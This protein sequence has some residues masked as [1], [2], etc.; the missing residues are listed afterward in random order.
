MSSPTTSTPTGVSTPSAPPHFTS[1]MLNVL[2]HLT[3]SELFMR[4][5]YGR[6]R[7][8]S[9][10]SCFYAWLGEVRAGSSCPAVEATLGAPDRRP[11]RRAAGARG[12]F[13]LL[14]PRTRLSQSFHLQTEGGALLSAVT[15]SAPR[16]PAAVASPDPGSI[17]PPGGPRL[18]PSVPFLLCDLDPLQES[19]WHVF[20]P[21]GKQNSERPH[22]PPIVRLLHVPRVPLRSGLAPGTRPRLL[23]SRSLPCCQSQVFSARGFQGASRCP[24]SLPAT[25]RVPPSVH[26]RG[27]RSPSDSVLHPFLCRNPLRDDLNTIQ[28]ATPSPIH[29]FKPNPLRGKFQPLSRGTRVGRRE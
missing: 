7:G 15:L 29:I 14:P 6:E 19:P 12:F 16:T 2:C 4:H 23:L 1:L 3:P 18:L 22:S 8:D 13:L 25:T 21:R 9:L 26:D 24:P 20:A 5:A 28:M 11:V 27:V 17:S 10:W